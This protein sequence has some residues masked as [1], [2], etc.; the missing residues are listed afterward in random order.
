MN[1]TGDDYEEVMILL[2]NLFL[3]IDSKSIKFL[4]PFCFVDI[5]EMQNYLSFPRHPKKMLLNYVQQHS[6][7]FNRHQIISIYSKWKS[8]VKF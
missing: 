7:E 5:R 6:P 4:N 1:P 3:F 2:S 8:P